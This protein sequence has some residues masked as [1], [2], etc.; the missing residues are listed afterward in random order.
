MVAKRAL[1]LHRPPDDEREHGERDRRL[2]EEDPVAL[3]A[4]LYLGVV[5]AAGFGGR[6][7]VQRGAR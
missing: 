5:N 1:L 7:E 2:D 4:W 3:H 6:D